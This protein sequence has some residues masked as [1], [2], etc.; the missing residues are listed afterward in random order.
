MMASI[1]VTYCIKHYLCDIRVKCDVV[2]SVAKKV[3]VHSGIN[4]EARAKGFELRV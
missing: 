2:A 1:T 4:K 3:L